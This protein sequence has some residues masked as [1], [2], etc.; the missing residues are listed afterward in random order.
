MASS[1]LPELLGVC[2]RIAVLRD[3]V[4]VAEMPAA[5]ATQE[6]LLEAATSSK[7]IEEAA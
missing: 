6:M 3:G 2:D 7:P 5:E 1:E 4:V